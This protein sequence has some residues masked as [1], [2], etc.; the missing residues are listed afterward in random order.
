MFTRWGNA[1]KS[2]IDSSRP[3]TEVQEAYKQFEL[4]YYELQ[5][6]HDAYA[7]TL[8]DSEFEESEQWMN[9]CQSSFLELQILNKDYGQTKKTDADSDPTPLLQDDVTDGGGTHMSADDNSP[10]VGIENDPPQ[11]GTDTSSSPAKDETSQVADEAVDVKHRSAGFEKKWMGSRFKM[12]KPKMPTFSGNVRE[13]CIFKADFHHAMGEC[14]NERDALMILRSCLQGK[15]L[16]MI[17]GIGHDYKAAWE[18]LDLVYGDDRFVADAI[19]HDISR[20]R[21]LKPGEDDRFCELVHLLRR[22]HNTLNEIGKES[23]MNNSHMIAIM[24]RKLTPED[25]RLWFR[26]QEASGPATLMMFMDWLVVEMKARMRASAPVRNEGKSGGVNLVTQT[27]NRR[28]Q[29]RCWICKTSDGHWTDQCQLFISKTQPER[30]QMVKDQFACFSCLKRAGKDHRMSTCRR[31]Q[32][33]TESFN[34]EQCKLFHHPLLHPPA[35]RGDVDVAFASGKEAVLPVLTAEVLGQGNVKKESNVLFDSGAQITLIKQSLADEMQLRGKDISISITKLGGEEEV[36]QTKVYKVPIRAVGRNKQVHSVS[37]IGLPCIN[38]HIAEVHLGSV[39]RHFGLGGD[40]INRKGGA[41]DILIGIDHPKLHGG[42]TREYGN[43]VARHTPL[44]WVVFGLSPQD[45]TQPSTI[46]HVQIAKPVDLTE[47]WSTETMGVRNGDCQCEQ[48]G[49]TKA[50]MDEYNI[51]NRLCK[52]MGKQWQVSYPWKRDPKD[53]PDN[54][55]Q[56]EKMLEATERK[57][58]KNPEYAKAYQAQMTEMVELGFARKLS[59]EEEKEYAGPKHYIAHHAVVRPEKR[60]TPVRIVF[61]SSSSFHGHSLNDYWHKGP[62]L[63]NSLFG[64]LIRFREH[65]VAICGDISKMYH[66]VK[67]PEIDQHVHR[68]LWRDMEVSRKSDTY[69]KTVL[70]FGDKPAPAMAQVA[71]KRT[72]EEAESTHPEAAM[73]LKESTYMD[74]ICASVETDQEARKLTDEMDKVLANGGFQVK[75]WLSNKSL[76]GESRHDDREMNLLQSLSEEKVLGVTWNQERDS[77]SYK[78]KPE[79]KEGESKPSPQKWTKR[80][81][82]SKIARLFD[83]IGFA[84]A[85]LVRAKM[86]IQRLWQL[87]VDW[88]D[89][90]PP[91]EEAKWQ[92][93]FSEMEQLDGVEF[94]RCLKPE[95]ATGKPTLCIFSDASDSAFGACAYLRW[96]LKDGT[97]TSR[98]VA[99][100]SRV[101]PLKKLTIPRLELQAAVT[102]TRLYAAIKKELGIHLEETIFMTDSLITM[103]WIRSESRAFKPFVSARIGEIQSVSNPKCWR[104]VPGNVNPADHISRGI[105]VSAMKDTWEHGPDFLCTPKDEWP[106]DKS[107]PEKTETDVEMRKVKRVLHMTGA[108]IINC[109]RFSSWRRVVRVTAY[110]HR[111]VKNLKARC[112][113]RDEEEVRGPLAPSELEHAEMYWVKMVQKPLHAR[114]KADEFK[115]LS[116]YIDG[117]V[118][119]VGGRAEKSKISYEMRHPVLLPQNHHVCKL[120]TRYYHQ[121][122]HGGVANTASK[123]R[124]RYWILGVHRL[125]KSVKFKCVKCREMEKRVESQMMSDLPNERMAPYTPPFHFTSCD[126]FGPMHVKVGRNKTAKHYGVIFTCLNT[127]AVHLELATDCSTMEFIQVLRRFLALRG[128]PACIMSDNGTQFVGAQRELR[129]MVQG[130]SI[131][132]LKDFCA[133]RRIEWKFVTPLAPHHNG[134]AEALVKSCKIALKKAIGD[135]QLKPFELFTCLQEVANLVNQRP[136]GRIPTDPDDGAYICPNDILLGRASSVVPQGPFKETKNPRHRVEFVQKIVDAFWRSWTRDVFPLLVPRRKWNVEKRNIRV[137]DVVM[138]SDPNAIRGKWTLGRITQVYPGD[139]GRVRTVK[140]KSKDNEYKRPITK[141]VVIYPAEGY[142]DD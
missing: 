104:F 25:R 100:K 61:N 113:K 111:Y 131:D 10:Q 7:E 85:F 34:G 56:A 84:G 53:L 72:A 135:Q 64:V 124:A 22:S 68:Y 102:A 140:V 63:L 137:G 52:Q 75:E 118:I 71:L 4:A 40:Q 115:T 23:D 74:D 33:C 79:G 36:F 70:T 8:E 49:M 46:L 5:T 94:P 107:V 92:G 54:R 127:R 21:P 42:E 139:D 1:L 28:P 69:I 77:F 112:R 97:F 128:Q 136:I 123:V 73:I 24:E 93:L 108:E 18:Q 19:I 62:D 57:L 95:G 58:R 41:V 129:E 99:A 132:E 13:Y 121:Q 96:A 89:G 32:R 116:P 76:R 55:W 78:V 82:L 142:Q 101:A 45:K 133:E 20:F 67:I 119:R 29:H 88:D 14:Y 109:E 51:I 126:Y 11:T 91:D 15:P 98:F 130:W 87:G 141:L 106:K 37:A 81:I 103:G 59:D 86:G 2:L 47:F 6:K 114:L 120:I 39:A 83:P 35:T 48:T 26:H 31:K 43:Y 65:P 117:D 3:G 38:D 66:R 12:E 125:A 80:K 138:V 16:Q 134:T 44:G 17:Q 90:I 105:S 60:S 9:E 50:D 27:E 110:V 122:G 30:V